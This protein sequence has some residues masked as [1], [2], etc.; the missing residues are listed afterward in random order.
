M[1]VSVGALVDMVDYWWGE[2]GWVEE[3]SG[4]VDAWGCEKGGGCGGVVVVVWDVGVHR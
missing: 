1:R 2:G 3:W 4:E